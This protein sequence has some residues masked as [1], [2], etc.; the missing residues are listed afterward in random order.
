MLEPRG[1]D[2]MFV[3]IITTPT[4]PEA[5]LG[6]IFMGSGGYLNMYGHGTIGAA[7]AAGEMGLVEVKEPE[8]EV[9]LE[10]PAGLVKAWVKVEK[11]KAKGVTFQNVTSFLF[12]DSD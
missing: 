8:T 3:S 1:H 9:V 12:K 10:A 11:G 4:I 2:D 6:I 5:D 7:T